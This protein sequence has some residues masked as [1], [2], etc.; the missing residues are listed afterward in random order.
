MTNRLET[1]ASPPVAPGR[2]YA[3]QL[4]TDHLRAD[5]KRRTVSS[6]AV[7]LSAQGVKFVLTMGSTAAMARLLTPQD[8]AWSR[9]SR[10]S[11]GFSPCSATQA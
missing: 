4:R 10:P 6:A 1:P 8:S 5:L 3:D 11:P 7:T 2:D 9:W